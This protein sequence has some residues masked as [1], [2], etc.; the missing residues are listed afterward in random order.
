MIRAIRTTPPKQPIALILH[1]PGG[2]VLAASQI[3]MALRRH[4]GK[5]IVIVPFT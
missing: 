3:A 5:K 2:L 1:T 4:E